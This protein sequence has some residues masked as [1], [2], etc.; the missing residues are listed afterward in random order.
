M[1]MEKVALEE[2][3]CM[4]LPS[5]RLQWKEYWYKELA[6]IYPYGL[7]DNVR[8]VGNIYKKGINNIVAMALYNKKKRPLILT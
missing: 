4:N 8:K 5:K 2:E 1:P 7:N 6:T 3:E